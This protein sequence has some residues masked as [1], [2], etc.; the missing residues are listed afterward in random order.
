M[1]DFS[2][3]E[4]PP[5][6]S[7]PPDRL[8]QRQLLLER[9]IAASGR[10]AGKPWWRRRWAVVP[11]AV[12]IAGSLAA[13]GWGLLPGGQA[14]DATTVSCYSTVNLDGDVGIVGSA[15]VA[16]PAGA[17]RTVWRQSGISEPATTAVCVT[18]MGMIAVFP[19]D[20]SCQKLGLRPFTGVS[21]DA[22][23]LAAFKEDASEAVA[24][25]PCQSRSVIVTM[26][27]QELDAHSLGTWRIDE[28]GYNQP[29]AEGRPCASLG[30]DDEGKNVIIVPMPPG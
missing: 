8:A 20:G 26:I 4:V 3:P 6:R 17:C 1:S 11:G 22:A 18:P 7:I 28:S 13:A 25:A 2:L 10:A 30:F 21:E 9:H 16:D 24:T 19:S 27:R 5:G 14:T 12:A 15:A 29:W 23:N